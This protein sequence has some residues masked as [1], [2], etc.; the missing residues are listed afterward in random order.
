M[1]LFRDLVFTKRD[2]MSVHIRADVESHLVTLQNEA[3][4]KS[5]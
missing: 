5:W 3:C 2:I 4:G 1:I